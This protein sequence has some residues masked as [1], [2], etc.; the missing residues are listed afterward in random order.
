MRTD[1]NELIKDYLLSAMPILEKEADG[2]VAKAV[3]DSIRVIF[4]AHMPEIKQAAKEYAVSEDLE[5]LAIS[6]LP[7]RTQIWYEAYGP[8]WLS[9]CKPVTDHDSETEFTYYNDLIDMYWAWKWQEWKKKDEWCVTIMLPPTKGLLQHQ[10]Y[11]EMES[12]I[13]YLKTAG[14]NNRIPASA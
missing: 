12:I 11:S 10:Y 9:H 5:T 14:V 13:K 6:L 7:I 2:P 1:V 4:D 3:I 8:Y